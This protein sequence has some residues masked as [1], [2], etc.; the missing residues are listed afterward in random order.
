MCFYVPLHLSVHRARLGTCPPLHLSVQYRTWL[1]G[2]VQEV[3][4]IANPETF[5]C[6]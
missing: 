3:G 5:R 2:G 4:G 6:D 1:G